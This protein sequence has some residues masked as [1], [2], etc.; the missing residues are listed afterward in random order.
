L[1]PTTLEQK[2]NPPAIC[3]GFVFVAAALADRARGKLDGE[4][5]DKIGLRN[6]AIENR[7]R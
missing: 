2:H 7:M 5:T 4:S 6:L 1:F 3:G